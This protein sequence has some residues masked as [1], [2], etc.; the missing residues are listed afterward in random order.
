[1][2]FYIISDVNICRLISC[3][4]NFTL[5]YHIL[6]TYGMHMSI[7]IYYTSKTR[8]NNHAYNKNKT[9]LNIWKRLSNGNVFELKYHMKLVY[10]LLHTW[11]VMTAFL[12]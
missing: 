6:H 7:N 12:F 11:E 5:F 8:K 1:M 2:C 3:L 10:N 9:R 4:K